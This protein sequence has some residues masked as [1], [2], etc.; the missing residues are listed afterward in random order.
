MTRPSVLLPHRCPPENAGGLDALEDALRDRLP[1]VEFQRARDREETAALISDAEIVIEHRFDD[2]LLDAAENLRWLQTLSSGY[3]RFDLDRLASLD[4]TLTTVSGVHATPI[5]Q[6]V[7]GCVLAFERGLFRARRQQRRRE[8]RRYAPDELTGKT[9]GI[10]GVG[11]IG[12]RVAELLAP[13]DV[14]VLGVKRDPSTVSDV[15]DAVYGPDERHEVLGR[16]DYVVVACPLT[17]E[18]RGMFDAGAF[19]SMRS[20]AILV[21]VA[22]GA[23]VDESA[24]VHAL[25]TGNLGGAVLDVAETEPPDWESPLWDFENVVLTPHMA[26]GSPRFADRVARLF[27]DNYERF[28]GGDLDAMDNRVL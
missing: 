3:D 18:T 16:S 24:L 5:A 11:S 17:E 10:V 25:Q 2:E 15:V 19:E 4:V 20:D 23:I 6:H 22:R 14:T 7:L 27:G 26:G 1:K 9:V 13:L 21:N 28:V 8:W 12:G